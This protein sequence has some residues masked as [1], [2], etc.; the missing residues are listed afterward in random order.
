MS[1]ATPTSFP[2]AGPW[3][4]ATAPTVQNVAQ[5]VHRLGDIPLHRVRTQPPPGAATV[6]DA[7]ECKARQNCLCELVDGVLVEKAMGYREGMIELAI[8]EALRV[9]NRTTKLGIVTPA[10]S[11]LQILPN[12]VRMPDV[13]FTFWSRFPQGK[14]TDDP[15][16]L[17]VPDLAVEVLSPSN[18]RREMQRKRAEYFAAGTQLVWMIDLDERTA[19]VFTSPEQSS[20]LQASDVLSGGAVLPGFSLPL[21]DVF[22]ELDQHAPPTDEPPP[23]SPRP[24]D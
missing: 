21:A 24:N 17:L 7:V 18:T 10:S 23:I 11:M 13:A 2:A 12:L 6:A 20:V 5:L 14:I 15:A 3:P 22:A 19:T 16:P 8:S 1:I 4:T 9:Y